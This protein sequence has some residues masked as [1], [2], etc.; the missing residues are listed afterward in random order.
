MGNLK[1]ELVDREHRE[2]KSKN[3]GPEET[4]DRTRLEKD[5]AAAMKRSL[6]AELE[7]QMQANQNRH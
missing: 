1:K 3:F 6:K 2:I 4:Q 5:L 7:A